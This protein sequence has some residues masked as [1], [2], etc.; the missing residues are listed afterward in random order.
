M[1]LWTD[2]HRPKGLEEFVG[3]SKAVEKANG[4][5]SNFKSG[6]AIML[7]GPTGCGKSLLVE[8]LAQQKEFFLIRLN[9]NDVSKEAVEDLAKSSRTKTLFTKGKIILID[10]AEGISGRDR[11]I[12]DA[13]I[14]LIKASIYPVFLI[15]DPYLQKLKS[16]K[17]NCELIKFDKVPVPS[18]VKRMRDICKQENIEVE[19]EALKA[20]AKFSGG[21]L[22]SSIIDLQIVCSGK[23][24][25][26]QKDLEAIGYREREQ[27]IFNILQPIFH[28][29]S[30]NVGR[31][32][33][34]QADKDSDEIFWWIEN[35]ITQEMK[36]PEEIIN[37]Y[38]LL[39]VADIF[40]NRI[41]KQQNWRFKALASDLM[42]SISVFKTS[43]TG[44]VMY[45]PPQTF[46]ML[47]R[48]KGQR[49]ELKSIY[50]KLG[51][52]LHCSTREIKDSHLPYLKIILK[53][54]PEVGEGI[55]L[56]KEDIKL[57]LSGW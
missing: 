28:S 11:G 47:G 8:L 17:E 12:M 43:H 42:A 50:Q 30:V 16:V 51:K 23:S 21:D 7:Y 5:I 1:E 2:K 52:K 22:R 15:G 46:A 31:N 55:D 6:K 49:G 13:V 35:N 32:S 40:R 19:E 25:V 14:Q 9:A 20:L 10:E 26:T 29:R 38:N 57:I 48:T 27:N 39:S 44:F 45:K 56:A 3:N 37:A 24:S 36:T 41:M 34:Q 33:I 4:Y 54:K 18:I 53:K